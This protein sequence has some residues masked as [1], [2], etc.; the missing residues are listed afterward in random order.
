MQCTLT[1]LIAF[2]ATAAALIATPAGSAPVA[3]ASIHQ[4]AGDLR[5]DFPVARV[6]RRG[7]AVAGPR[8]GAYVRRGAAAVGPRGCRRSAPDHRR[9]SARPRCYRRRGGAI[10]QMGTSRRVLVAAGRR[11]RRGRCD[12]F[13]RCSHR[14]GLGRRTARTEYVLVLHRS[15][16]DSGLLGPVPLKRVRVGCR[17]PRVISRR[18]SLRCRS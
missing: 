18:A 11:C 8:G 4:A 7:V 15:L 3:P 5:L 9:R 2:S 16:T 13:C 6:G 12:R 1:K 17:G 14:G 10:R